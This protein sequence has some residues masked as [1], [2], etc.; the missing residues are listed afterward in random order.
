[1]PAT[2]CQ[3]K[4]C[5]WAVEIGIFEGGGSLWVQISDGSHFKPCL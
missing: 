4:L 5:W 3:S 1:M 2:C